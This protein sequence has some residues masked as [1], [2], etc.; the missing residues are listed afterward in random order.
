MNVGSDLWMRV[1][2]RVLV[3]RSERVKRGPA[4]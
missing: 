2:R 1:D 3:C 4:W